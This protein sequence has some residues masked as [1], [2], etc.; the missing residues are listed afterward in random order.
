MTL[1]RP[2][3][4]T[5]LLLGIIAL[6]A[7][8]ASAVAPVLSMTVLAVVIVALA[9]SLS[10]ISTLALM[11]C[12]APLRTLIA[13]E[14]ALQLP[15]DVGQ[16]AFVIFVFVWWVHRVIRKRKPFYVTQSPLL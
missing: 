8:F 12:V 1:T 14:S 16:I 2:T 6:T 4:Y 7:G 3:N 10:P 5:P 9:M 11:L 15:L 13:T